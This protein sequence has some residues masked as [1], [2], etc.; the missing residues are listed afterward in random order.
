MKFYSIL[1]K[2]TP[3]LCLLLLFSCAT[4]QEVVYYQNIQSIENSTSSASYEIKIQPDDLLNI[5]VSAEDPEIAIP[6]NLGSSTSTTST[7]S[8]SSSVSSYLVDVNGYI[9]FPVLGRIKV[10]GLLRSEVV[11]LFHSKLTKYIKNP[12]VNLRLMNFKFA[13]QG[14]FAA[15]GVYTI[16]SE[17]LTLVEAISKGGDL[18]IY[19]ERNNILII[20]ENNGVK[21]YNRIDITKADFINSP[22]YYIAQNDVI[23][24]EPNKTKVHSSKIGSDTSLIFS[25]VS[26]LLTL[27]TF[28]FSI[29]K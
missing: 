23:Y 10:G 4:K 28:I 9:E 7:T 19:G 29:T 12:I 14:E 21:T 25:S 24:V 26:I 1:K 6:F 22:F 11:A 15:P 8:S 3:L 18:T 17:R 2:I 16:D 13:L 27:V 20:R 5:T